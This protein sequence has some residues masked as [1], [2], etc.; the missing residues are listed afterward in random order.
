MISPASLGCFLFADSTAM[1]R[2]SLIG[3]IAHKDSSATIKELK[4][5]SALTA[6][7]PVTAQHVD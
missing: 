1:S 4:L 6:T 7:G 5:K 3:K 2:R